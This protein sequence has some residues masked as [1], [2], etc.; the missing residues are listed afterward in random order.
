LPFNLHKIIVD[1]PDDFEALSRELEEKV[2]A[3]TAYANSQRK[4]NE[5]LEQENSKLKQTL[6][7]IRDWFKYSLNLDL[8]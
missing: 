8:D 5:R 1:G 4:E 7:T 3:V 6:S 2:N